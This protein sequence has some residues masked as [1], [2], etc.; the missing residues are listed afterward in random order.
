MCHIATNTTLEVSLQMTV[1]ELQLYGQYK[2]LI[3]SD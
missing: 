3:G 1:L 2:F